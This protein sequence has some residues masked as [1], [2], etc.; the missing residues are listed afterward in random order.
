MALHDVDKDNEDR[1]SPAVNAHDDQKTSRM[2]HGTTSINPVTDATSGS[3]YIDTKNGRILVND[4]TNNRIILGVWPDGTFGL[5]I[6]KPGF[7]ILDQF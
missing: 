4:G 1:T 6:S 7:D 5:I 3:A 2:A